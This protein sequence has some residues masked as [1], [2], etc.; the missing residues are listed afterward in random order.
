MRLGPSPEGTAEK[1]SVLGSISCLVGTSS[2][3]PSNPTLTRW[4]ILEVYLRDKDLNESP[5]GVGANRHVACP[6]P[7]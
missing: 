2:L 5:G 3:A 6:R 1:R 4:D 7:P